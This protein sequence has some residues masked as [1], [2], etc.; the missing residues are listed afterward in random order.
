MLKTMQQNKLL[1][2]GAMF[3]ASYAGLR[4][5]HQP[6]RTWRGHTDSLHAV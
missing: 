2:A 5:G 3:A 6:G 1:I 4:A